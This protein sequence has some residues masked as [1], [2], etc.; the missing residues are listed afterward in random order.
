MPRQS[1]F[2]RCI[3][4][5]YLLLFFTA[6]S[7]DNGDDKI[8][9]DYSNLRFAEIKNKRLVKTDIDTFSNYIKNGIRLRLE[10]GG[11]AGELATVDEL[12]QYRSQF[13]T[14]NV[15]EIGVDEDDRL[16]YDGEYLYLVEDSYFPRNSNADKPGIRIVQTFSDSSQVND[17]AFIKSQSDNLVING[18]YLHTSNNKNALLSLSGT[19]FLNGEEV[20][21]ESDWRWGSGKSEINLYDISIPEMPQH[22]WKLE[23]EGNL[24]GSR[25]IGN[26]LYLITHFIPHI[27]AIN[28]NAQT[29]KERE[30]NERLI[31]NT[32]LSDLMPHYQVNNGGVRV[33]TSPNDC[34][35]NEGFSTNEGYADILMLVEVNLDA[36]EVSSSTC[37]NSRVSGIYSSM[38][39][40][41]IGASGN[42]SWH[43]SGV[44]TNIHKFNLGGQSIEYRGT[45]WVPGLVGRADSD[46]A[47]W[48]WG[49]PALRMSEKNEHLRIVT[50]RRAEEDFTHQLYILKEDGT[51]KLEVVAQLPNLDEPRAIGKPGEDI[52]AV[53]FVGDKAYIITFEQTDPLYQIDLSNP[54]FPKIVTELEIPGFARYLHPLVPGWLLGI[55]HQVDEGVRKG[56]KIEL[57]DLSVIESPQ[58]KDSIVIGAQGSWSEAL[59]NLK[60]VSLLSL[61]NDR[62]RLAFPINRFEKNASN[63]SEWNE[64]GLF[65]FEISGLNS[66][67]LNLRKTGALITEQRSNGH[68]YP[69]LWGVGRSVLSGNNLYYYQGN[70]LWS[71][72][73]DEISNSILKK[74]K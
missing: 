59:N 58:V 18:L 42:V 7:F 37:L 10:T 63:Q 30:E 21:I 66:H 23:I 2:C 8:N 34:L 15:H 39:N 54:E 67:L 1:I 43:Q 20:L 33:L 3:V 51:N 64:S 28:S 11:A 50:S 16:K 53:R 41:Y 36:R 62:I 32:P 52:Y 27:A 29:L 73:M 65:V 31:L 25:K 38:H 26:K 48:F 40:L 22:D 57:Y 35:V 9:V 19:R 12:G 68:F 47:W 13:S 69:S 44:G 14:T 49:D 45:G 72:S 71:T 56:V 60:S 74:N 17:V 4:P 46:N 61:D 5:F 55:G 24:E 70:K 6:C